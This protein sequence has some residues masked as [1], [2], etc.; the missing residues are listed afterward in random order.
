MFRE[1]RSSAVL[2]ADRVSLFPDAI[3][4]DLVHARPRGLRAAAVADRLRDTAVVYAAVVIV[5]A[6]TA[7]LASELRLSANKRLA[8]SA[9]TATA[10]GHRT[11]RP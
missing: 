1:Q 8:T 7:A 5:L 11:T 4:E 2:G 6:L 9:L 3:V 10:E